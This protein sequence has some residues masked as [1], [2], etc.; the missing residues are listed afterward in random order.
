[1]AAVE[2]KL[3]S[4]S[5]SGPTSSH[6]RVRAALAVVDLRNEHE[7]S[8]V[9]R[10]V[11]GNLGVA[12]SRLL[13]LELI[14]HSE[15]IGRTEETARAQEL[16]ALKD[17]VR[18]LMVAEPSAGSS[19][20]HSAGGDQSHSGAGAADYLSDMFEFWQRLERSEI[21]RHLSDEERLALAVRFQLLL[22][23]WKLDYSAVRPYSGYR[24]LG[25]W[26]FGIVS[27][28][29]LE[30]CGSE[31]SVAVK[32]MDASFAEDDVK[33]KFFR[34]AS[35]LYT[36]RHPAIV[37]LYGA[38]WPQGWISL[39]STGDSTRDSADSELGDDSERE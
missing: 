12:W 21:G 33:A 34:E 11:F 18:D 9:L 29:T 19:S 16:A 8:A 3:I 27:R 15:E 17:V 32:V 4:P 24:I 39:A 38:W 26:R 22:A 31:V 1:M 6:S 35:M 37:T 28:G 2:T 36:L 25:F 14:G 23:P 30:L 20:A 5:T 10:Y 13:A 7:V